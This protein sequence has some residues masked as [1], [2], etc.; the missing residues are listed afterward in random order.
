MERHLK[1]RLGELFGLEYDLLLYDVTS[2]YF[3]GECATNGQAQRGYS[4]DH[5]P[6]CKQVC[7]A[8]VVSREGMPLGYEVFHGNRADV[9][10]VEEMVEK[11]ETQYG[12]AGR[13]WVMDRGMVSE[14]N[15]EYLRAGGRRYIAGTPRGLLRRFEREL[16]KADWQEV[17]QGLEVKMCPSPNGK[18]SFI[19]CRSTARAIKEKQIHER[20]EKRIERGLA[21]LI[22]SCRKR[23]QK[24]GVIERRVGRLLGANSRAAG[25]FRVEVTERSEGG[26]E[27]VWEKVEEWRAWAELSEGC[28]L[29]RSNIT[30]WGAE[31][32]WQAYIQLTEAEA[33]FRIQKGD[34]RIRPIWHQREERVQAHILV[35]FLAYVLWKILGQ[36]CKRAGLGDE[37]RK[38]LDEIAQIKAVDVV[39]P[40]RQGVTIR[41]RCIAQPSK[42]QAILL[43]RLQLH[44]PQRM[45]ITKCSVDASFVTGASYI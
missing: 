6:D 25:L 18:E 33:A 14:E 12:S 17:R 19:L 27:V 8:L 28:Y 22:E 21:K 10:T 7:I 26:T 43:Q 5:R 45:V 39:L 32:L 20:F 34:L 40:T 4:R 11:I 15:L 37:P 29:L 44:L 42:A 41:K 23:K 16:L 31:E 30:D 24:V 13:I 38:V 35:C 3:E 36:M 9:T 1:G 2:T